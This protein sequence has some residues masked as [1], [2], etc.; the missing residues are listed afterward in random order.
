MADDS[1]AKE[2][3]IH[4]AMVSR[5]DVAAQNLGLDPGLTQYLRAPERE[6]ILHLPV[7]MDSGEL[8]VFDAYRVQHSIARGPSKGGVRFAPDVTPG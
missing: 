8:R 2:L 5:Y 7:V 4:Q 6:I 1:W 3:N